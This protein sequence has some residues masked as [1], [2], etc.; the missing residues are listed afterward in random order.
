[1]LPGPDGRLHL[2]GSPFRGTYTE[3]PP[4]EGSFPLAAGFRIVKDDHAEVR[5]T[6]RLRAL[7][8]LVGN[9]PFVADSLASRPELFDRLQASVADVP[10]QH[11]HFRKDD[12]YWDAI[13]AAGL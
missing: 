1:M 9:L 3:G 6:S 5:P 4:V 10:L 11:L 2:V 7:S 12:S 13:L 8:E